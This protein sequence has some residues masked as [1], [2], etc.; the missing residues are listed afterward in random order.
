MTRDDGAGVAELLAAAFDRGDEARL[1]EALARD[2]DLA[3]A[4]VA[5]LDGTLAGAAM[6]SHLVAPE[7]CLG[8]GPIAVAE[9]ARHRGVGGALIGACV[10]WAVEND[11]NGIFVLGRP[12]YYTRFGFT[13]E[14]AAGFEHP[15]PDEFMLAR[16]IGE[17]RLPDGG[18][19]QYPP[20]FAALG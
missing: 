2:G 12:R 10:D 18:A 17:D 4:L 6:L 13:V 1:V 11:R 20:A 9:S 14:R 8:L 15:W 3:V 5:E 19:L 16:E 7:D